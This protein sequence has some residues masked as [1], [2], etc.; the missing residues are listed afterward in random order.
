MS[1][2][3]KKRVV[4]LGILLALPLMGLAAEGTPAATPNLFNM[5]LIATSTPAPSAETPAATPNLFDLLRGTPAPTAE[6]APPGTPNLFDILRGTPA[7]VA[8]STL[9]TLPPTAEPTPAVAVPRDT[10]ALRADQPAL[11][12]TNGATVSSGDRLIAENANVRL[13]LDEENCLFKVE[14]RAN[15]YVFSSS[16]AAERVQAL[17]REWQNMASSLV[18]AESLN[19]SGTSAR[20]FYRVDNAEEPV[21]TI[22]EDGFS[23]TLHFPAAALRLTVS[24]TLTETGFVIAIPHAGILEEGG[25]YLSRIQVLPF[26]GAVEGDTI[27]G[28]TLL[29]D[30]CGAL[31][32]FEKPANYLAPFSARVYG[33]DFGTRRPSVRDSMRW[34]GVTELNLPLFGMAHG[35]DWAA[36]LALCKQGE[37]FMQIEAAPAGVMTAFHRVY[38]SF[39]YREPYSQPTGRSSASFLA[40]PPRTNALDVSMEYVLLS[41]DQAN[42]SG[43]AQVYRQRLLDGGTLTRQ[44]DSEVPL[45]L[46]VLMGETEKGVIGSSHLVMTT[47]QQAHD[48]LQTLRSGGIKRVDMSLWGYANGGVSAQT[49][50]SPGIST[51]YGDRDVYNQLAGS[52]VNQ[53]HFYLETAVVTGYDQQVERAGLAYN[54]DGGL[55]TM[56]ILD[57]PLF[58]RQSF[59]NLPYVEGLLQQMPGDTAIAIQDIGNQLHS[60]HR[61]NRVQPRAA[62]LLGYQ[63]ALKMLNQRMQVALFT[64]YA[65][66]LAGVDAAMEVPM[67]NSQYSY[68]S[69]AVPFYQMV[70]SGCADLFS[71]PLNYGGGT[72]RE[73][74]QL[75]DYNVSPAYLVTSKGAGDLRM[76][77]TTDLYSSRFSDWQDDM[78]AVYERIYQV[79]RAVRGASVVSRRVPMDGV[80][81]LVYDNGVVVYVNYT[82]TEQTVDGAVIAAESAEMAKEVQP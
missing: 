27:P 63:N 14:N 6:A 10:M 8:T 35:P 76:S 72:K 23:V 20:A 59:Q 44:G 47:Y 15:G 68:Q 58:T 51:A 57:K 71:T 39:I 46:R 64:P 65:Y 43:M 50:G 79:Q 18:V 21:Y 11:A 62:V 60:D 26:F 17:N 42:Y 66:A 49:L 31:M 5:L 73:A 78:L 1:G 45:L 74:L 41:G 2:C 54:V 56:D 53:G 30:G 48:F 12:V 33:Q 55:I 82:A 13:Y 70:L 81:K 7:P 61:E 9:Q 4:L 77:N 36:Y 22:G 67:K 32:R 80:V 34:A 75:I 24:V 38:A 29:P 16:P 40:I 3:G 69:D 37:A 28:Y 19:A 52:V 25:M